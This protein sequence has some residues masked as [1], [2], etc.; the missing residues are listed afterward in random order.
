MYFILE[1]AGGMCVWTSEDDLQTLL[2]HV[3]HRNQT[4]VI[5]LGG[6]YL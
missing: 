2:H 4:R 6:P 5:R 1:E 3:G